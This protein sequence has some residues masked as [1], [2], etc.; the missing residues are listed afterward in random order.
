METS[1]DSLPTEQNDRKKELDHRRNIK[2]KFILRF[3][4]CLLVDSVCYKIDV[5]EKK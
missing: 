2:E 3:P 4:E 5:P 1:F